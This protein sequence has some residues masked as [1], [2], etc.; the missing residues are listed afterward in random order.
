METG[1]NHT[2]RVSAQA[3]ADSAR[4][5]RLGATASL[6][7]H[8]RL[9]SK[10]LRPRGHPINPL[11]A[12]ES[13]G[14]PSLDFVKAAAALHSPPHETD[15]ISSMYTSHG[16]ALSD[17]DVEDHI[18]IESFASSLSLHELFDMVPDQAS[19]ISAIP[20]SRLPSLN[21]A[22]RDSLGRSTGVSIGLTLSG[23]LS[24][25]EI[26]KYRAGQAETLRAALS[27]QHVFSLLPVGSGKTKIIEALCKTRRTDLILLVVPLRA[28]ESQHIQALR[29][30]GIRASSVRDMLRNLVNPQD[31]AQIQCL[32]GS[33]EDFVRPG[34]KQLLC[35][36]RD[37]RS[38]LYSCICDEAHTLLRWKKFRPQF[39]AISW[40]TE[41]FP[42]LPY[43]LLS[44][45]MSDDLVKKTALLL[46]ISS[47]FIIRPS[48]MVENP[49]L[50]LDIDLRYKFTLPADMFERI[51]CLTA[52][53]AVFPVGSISMAFVPTKSSGVGLFK[54]LCAATHGDPEVY[55]A[56]VCAGSDEC[57]EH[58][59]RGVPA[60]NQSV[61]NRDADNDPYQPPIVRPD[62]YNPDPNAMLPQD[63]ILQNFKISKAR[64]KILIS[65]SFL[66]HGIHMSEVD[67]VVHIGMATSAEDFWQEAGRAG[68][69]KTGVSL[70]LPNDMIADSWEASASMTEIVLPSGLVEQSAFRTGYQLPLVAP[71]PARDSTTKCSL[72]AAAE[73]SST[74]TCLRYLLS[75]LLHEES[76]MSDPQHNC[77]H[78]LKQP[79]ELEGFV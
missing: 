12:A 21:D 29:S 76:A 75:R 30:Q 62:T 26:R 9:S 19:S 49:R 16:S 5:T 27:R 15:N 46:G 40:L 48:S 37:L 45:T 59:Y 69:V 73:T 58:G 4:Y 34:V 71:P 68:R 18:N 32:V 79:L 77:C 11:S 74:P 72:D 25:L 54:A 61:I 66:S 20:M 10:F 38:R 55:V 43:V 8:I 51:S 47:F 41:A 14:L 70:L 7:W 1:K 65:T 6:V 57:I 56:F 13:A 67:R 60:Q 17:F 42:R 78:N 39:P 28:L 36:D 50:R 22:V 24:N 44:G 31:R 2:E 35:T 64:T 63:I 23:L 53:A 52:E 3:Y 33:P